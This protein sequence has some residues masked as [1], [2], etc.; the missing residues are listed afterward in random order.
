MDESE[1]LSSE[2]GSKDF[3]KE[4]EEREKEF[5]ESTELEKE[6]EKKQKRTNI[7]IKQWILNQFLTARKIKRLY[8][9]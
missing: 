1:E 3:E 9:A 5:E 6:E 4:G 2:T 7:K 8:K